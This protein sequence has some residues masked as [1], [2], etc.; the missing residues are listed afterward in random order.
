MSEAKYG[1]YFFSDPIFK[2]THPDSNDQNVAVKEQIVVYGNSK[3]GDQEVEC[4][5]KF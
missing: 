4:S 1:I 2:I 5:I 3:D